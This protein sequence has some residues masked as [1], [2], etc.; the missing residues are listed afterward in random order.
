MK[1]IHI[2]EHPVLAG[3]VVATLALIAAMT[4]AVIKLN[5][6]ADAENAQRVLRREYIT[7]TKGTITEIVTIAGET[8]RRVQEMHTVA[9]V[10]YSD[11]GVTKTATLPL[12]PETVV[13]TGSIVKVWVENGKPAITPPLAFIAYDTST[14][15]AGLFFVFLVA[16]TV[17]A[18]VS[19][20]MH[21][22]YI[23]RRGRR[24]RLARGGLVN[25]W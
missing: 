1:K 10:T 5:H 7:Q 21:E 19:T 16:L 4:M 6:I 13:T 11:G 3:A 8:T 9:D 2:K 20:V 14:P 15:L 12:E 25:N 22:N 24:E 17:I 18:V 23:E